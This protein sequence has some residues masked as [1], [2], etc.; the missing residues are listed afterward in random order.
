MDTN[1]DL[2]FRETSLTVYDETRET[3]AKYIH[4]EKEDIALVDNASTAV[5]AVLRSLPFITSS[6]KPVYILHMNIAYGMV[7][8]VLYYL[9][10]YYS[11]VKLVEVKIDHNNIKT[12]ELI[13]ET[14]KAA[15]D[16]ALRDNKN[17]R[18]AVFD[19]ISSTPA[20]VMP[21]KELASLF[22]S[23]NILTLVDGAHAIG[24]LPIRVTELGVS[25]Y[26]SNAH[27]W[28]F[29]PK[30]AAFLWV[31]KDLQIDTRPTVVSF[32]YA[33]KDFRQEFYWTGTRDYSAWFTIPYALEWRKQIGGEE[34]IMKYNN[35]LCYDVSLRVA[36]I[37][38]TSILFDE[39][40]R[41][42]MSAAMVN[43]LLP[44]QDHQKLNAAVAVLMKQYGTYLVVYEFDGMYY[45]RLSCQVYNE[46]SD[47]EKVAHYLL[48]V[49]KRL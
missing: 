10:D 39:Q 38:N 34:K 30:A 9:R 27:K 14:V 37:W 20:V 44:S 47:F 2:W 49:L 18:L 17:I 32:G 4:A 3:L 29:A 24:Q 45:T 25:Y 36:E 8:E 12:P 11:H 15:L 13:V 42:S 7:K 28:L 31:Q 22:K 35:D 16:A 6:T 46:I 5:N 48:T 33:S 26:L 19:H 23:R 43:V 21:I 40:Y 41:R 1:C